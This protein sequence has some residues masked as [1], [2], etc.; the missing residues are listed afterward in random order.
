MA[1]RQFTIYPPKRK[2]KRYQLYVKKIIND[3]MIS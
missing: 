1:V 2:R 3:L